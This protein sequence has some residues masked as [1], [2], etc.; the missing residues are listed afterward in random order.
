[1]TP[2]RNEVRKSP[3]VTANDKEMNPVRVFN[4]GNP[5]IGL[6]LEPFRQVPVVDLTI[7]APPGMRLEAITGMQ[8]QITSDIGPGPSGASNRPGLLKADGHH[9]IA[10]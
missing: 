3:G 7:A 4:D 6:S 1:M 10:G 2:T 8:I 5:A 9:A